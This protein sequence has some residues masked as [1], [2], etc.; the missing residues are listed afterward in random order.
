MPDTCVNIEGL[1][2]GTDYLA[3]AAA[4]NA[5]GTGNYSDNLSFTGEGIL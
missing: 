3:R 1:V 4:V 5:A 2:N